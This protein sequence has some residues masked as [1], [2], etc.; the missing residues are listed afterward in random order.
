MDGISLDEAVVM[1]ISALLQTFAR[2]IRFPLGL[3][4]H[5][6]GGFGGLIPLPGAG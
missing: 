4:R 5:P 6:M 2:G 1:F 3:R